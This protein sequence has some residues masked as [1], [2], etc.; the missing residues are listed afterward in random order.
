MSGI[1]NA[2]SD[3]YTADHVELILDNNSSTRMA[4]ICNYQ[5]STNDFYFRVVDNKWGA[6]V[7]LYNDWTGLNYYGGLLTLAAGTCDSFIIDAPN[8]ALVSEFS[9]NG[10][11][12]YGTNPVGYN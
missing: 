2:A 3:S 10:T 11:T 9:P 7:R 8:D 4:D 5:S 12:W 6:T 1:A